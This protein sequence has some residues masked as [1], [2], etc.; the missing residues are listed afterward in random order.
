MGDAPTFKFGTR[1]KLTNSEFISKTHSRSD[2]RDAKDTPGPGAHDPK[3]EVTGNSN[4]FK[5]NHGWG[6]G[7]SKRAPLATVKF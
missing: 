5:N 3:G 1:K 4:K 7:T 2:K 6:F